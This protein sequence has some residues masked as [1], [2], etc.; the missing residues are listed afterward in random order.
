M[1]SSL[2]HNRSEMAHLQYMNKIG[3]DFSVIIV[4]L[5]LTKLEGLVCGNVVNCQTIFYS[6]HEHVVGR[7]PPGLHIARNE[8]NR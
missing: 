5:I 4:Q 8:L 3:N 2:Q 6:H 7:V 1:I